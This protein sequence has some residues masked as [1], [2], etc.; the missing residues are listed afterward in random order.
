MKVLIAGE[1]NVDLVLQ[2]Y[3]SFPQ[4]GKEV[5]AEDVSLT[6]GSA[7]AICAAGLARLGTS[8]VFV[9]KVGCDAWGDLTLQRLGELGIDL[10]YVIRDASIKTGLTVSITSS[11]DR[12]LITYLGSIA[13]LRASDIRDDWFPAFRHIHVSSFY[14]QR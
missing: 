6:L 3:S 7:S 14:L 5:L 12:A 2:G 13:E 10:Q 4:L 11:K 8:V 1:L 9:G